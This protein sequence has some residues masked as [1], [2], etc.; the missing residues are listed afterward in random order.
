MNTLVNGAT[1]KTAES[2]LIYSQIGQK[3]EKIR[4]E[5]IK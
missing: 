2:G 1:C 4:S 5:M 3:I